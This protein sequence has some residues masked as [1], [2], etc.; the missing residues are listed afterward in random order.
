MNEAESASKPEEPEIFARSALIGAIVP[1]GIAT[2]EVRGP[3]TVPSVFPEEEVLLGKA[4][5]KRRREFALGRACAR[6]ALAE[7]GFS[8]VAIPIGARREPLWPEGVVGSITHCDGY[9]AAALGRR[10]QFAGIGIDAEIHAGLPQGVL[11]EVAL[12]DERRWIEERKTSGVSWDRLLFSAKE[13]IYKA[14]FPIARS[15]LGFKD[16]RITFDPDRG[17]FCGALLATGLPARGGTIER[18]EGRYLF[19]EDLLITAAFLNAPLD[20]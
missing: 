16:V 3:A 12:G 8:P 6:R 9:C 2:A 4:V 19:T 7:L 17:A 13:S 14:W 1:R 15:W 10:E 11:G 18:I 20:A 5:E